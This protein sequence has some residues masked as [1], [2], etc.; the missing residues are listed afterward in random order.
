MPAITEASDSNASAY[1]ID[2]PRGSASGSARTIVAGWSGWGLL[3][4]L[5]IL[6]VTGLTWSVRS[7]QEVLLHPDYW[8]PSTHA[9][10]FAVYA[11]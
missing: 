11:F 1:A 4:R 5:T 9:E 2:G 7:A 3:V 8:N 10:Y 6:V